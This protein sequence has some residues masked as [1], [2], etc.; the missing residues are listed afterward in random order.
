MLRNQMRDRAV[1][2]AVSAVRLLEVDDGKIN[3]CA[4]PTR[5]LDKGSQRVE[6]RG[7]RAASKIEDERTA[8]VSSEGEERNLIAVFR[9]AIV[10]EAKDG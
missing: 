8:S 6:E 2:P 3:R 5:R 10:E 9:F 1:H 4:V 7:S